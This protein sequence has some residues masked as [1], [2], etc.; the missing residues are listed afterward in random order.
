MGL[1]KSI[2][3]K[4]AV[5]LV[6][7]GALAWAHS[8]LAS[9]S[10]TLTP[11]DRTHGFGAIT[12]KV[13]VAASSGSCAWAVVNTNS[14]VTI[15]SG[16]S[17]VGN[18]EVTYS[19]PGNSSPIA[20]AGTIL[21]G[22][23]AFTISQLGV[24]CTYSIAPTNHDKCFGS[25]TGSVQVSTPS[26]CNWTIVNTNDWIL[27]TSGMAG[28]GSD[29][30]FY[31]VLGNNALTPRIGTV[32][33]AG[34]PF[35]INQS[36]Y[37]VTC[38]PDKQVECGAAWNFDAPTLNSADATIQSVTTVTNLECG[39][40]FTAIRTWNVTDHCGNIASCSQTVSARDVTP[41]AIFCAADKSAECGSQWTFDPPTANDTCD[42]TAVAIS[43][44][45]TVT[46]LGCGRSFTAT[47]K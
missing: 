45:T 24:V 31:T 46:N 19:I 23:E 39:K 34:Q 5:A 7:L 21:I 14:W 33:I 29:K 2:R 22:G 43:I 30:V 1:Q 32:L 27:I 16:A 10:F 11:G 15:V 18:G 26:S 3:S 37:S 40:S 35:V 25:T 20:R 41:P 13:V 47:P 42:G 8:A 12:A 4:L 6:A 17:G 36:A 9:C 44:F 28:V 38:A